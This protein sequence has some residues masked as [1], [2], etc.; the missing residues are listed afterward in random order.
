MN[1][2]SYILSLL[3][4]TSL[5]T[6]HAHAEIKT[7]EADSA[8]V[9]GDNDS[10]VDA[11]RIATQDAKRKALELAGT[12]VASLTQVKEYKLTKDEVTA[13]TAGI[14]ETE[15]IADET[16]GSLKHPELYIKTRC[17]IDTDVLMRQIESYRES[18]ELRSQLETSSKES[19]ALRKERDELRKQ[20]AAEKDKPKAEE[21]RKKLDTVLASEESIDDTNRVWAAVSKNIDFFDPEAK[22]ETITQAELDQYSVSMQRAVKVNPRNQRARV[23]LASLL[24][25]K[26]DNTA[27]E[28]ELRT[29]IAQD[30]ANPLFH[31]K[32][33]LLFKDQGRND[34]ALKEFHFIEQ[35]RPYDPHMLFMTGIT[36]KAKGNCKL[37]VAYLKRFIRFTQRNDKPRIA[38]MREKAFAVMRSCG[39]ASPRERQNGP[40]PPR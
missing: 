22:Q 37:T 30:P 26:G 2:T 13:Y 1:K 10:K 15:I 39:E 7:I 29:A 40:R 28:N 12:Y 34:E 3:I 9:M 31:M 21:T 4:I 17:K 25:R 14:V 16:R 11:R 6:H 23:L 36:H 24:Q 19:E 27:T 35:K 8:Y 18:E 33:G 20:L 32:L 38:K 5:L